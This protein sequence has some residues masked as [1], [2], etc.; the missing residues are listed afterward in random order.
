M[1]A[2]TNGRAR[3]T[4][5]CLQIHHKPCDVFENSIN[6]RQLIEEGATHDQ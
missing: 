1:S 4:D 3:V 6:Q 2:Y 5:E